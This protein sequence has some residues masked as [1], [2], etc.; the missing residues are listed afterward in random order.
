MANTFKNDITQNV[1]TSASSVYTAGSGVTATIIGMTCSNTT[2]TDV[3]I[4]VQVTDTSA[5]VT[6][7]VVKAAP[8]PTGGSLVVVGGNQKIVLETSDV[9]KVTSSANSSIDV[10]LSIMEQT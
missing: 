4:D 8:V 9:L 1:G 10:V 6:G 2:G 7:Y 3:T 5:G